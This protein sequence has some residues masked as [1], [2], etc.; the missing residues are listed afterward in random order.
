MKAKKYFYDII[1]AV[2]RPEMNILPG[3]LA[4]Y[5]VLALIPIITIIVY[6]DSLFSISIDLVIELI[7]KVIPDGVA[8]IVIDA[9]SGKGFDESVGLFIVLALIISSNGTYAMINASNALYKIEDTEEIK[10]RI[11]S[12]IILFII[13]LLFIFLL[14]VPLFGNQILN[15]LSNIDGLDTFIQNITILYNGIKWPMTFLIIYFNIKLIYT[16]SPSKSIKSNTTS[17]GAMTTTFL[18]VLVTAIFTYYLK[19]FA[20]YDIL[21]GNL[22]SLII[23]MIWVYLL[24]YIFVLGM[25]INS[26]KYNKTE[27][28]NNKT[29]Y[30]K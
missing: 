7:N 3:N 18:W 24:C 20:R 9:I 28:G 27:K 6:I 30:I 5:I 1:D 8:R 26:T 4:Y 21:Y 10:D 13:I 17:Y 14:V 15:L 2:K 19:H 11:K 23:L 16:I 29:E 25:A 12:I 22:S